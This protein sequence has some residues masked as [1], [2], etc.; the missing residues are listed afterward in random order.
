[1]DDLS[2]GVHAKITV[3]NLTLDI[4]YSA[5][6]AEYDTDTGSYREI[7][8][9]KIYNSAGK[10]VQV[11]K[12]PGMI[13][14]EEKFL[15][16]IDVNFDGYVDLEIF[17]HDGGAGPNYGN[18]YYIFNPRTGLFDF[19]EQLSALSQPLVSS[20]TKSIYSSYRAG[21]GIHGQE[22]YAWRDGTLTLVEFYET[23]YLDDDNVSVTHQFLVDG[24][25]KGES[26]IIKASELEG[27]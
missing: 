12:N 8:R 16:T 17:S 13:V 27:K 23:N 25:M 18:N 22:T 6:T 11:L 24:E 21:A 5:K 2:T 14:G 19:N 1:M 3:H 15:D 4:L 20:A 7:Q 9:I 10:L 26:K